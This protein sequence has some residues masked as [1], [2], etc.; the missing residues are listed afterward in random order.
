MK[1]KNFDEV[2][3]REQEKLSTEYVK[4]SEMERIINNIEEQFLEN[5]R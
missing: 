3:S 1:N 2:L 4:R 5:L